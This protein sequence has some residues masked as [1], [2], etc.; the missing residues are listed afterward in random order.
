MEP[1]PPPIS[2]DVADAQEIDLCCSNTPWYVVKYFVLVSISVVIL[3]F[4]IYN[5]IA[6][7]ADNNTVYF[8]LISMIIGI[9]SPSPSSAKK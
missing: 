3:T 9:F 2:I 1:L 4:C 8:S 6:H 5:I 7:P